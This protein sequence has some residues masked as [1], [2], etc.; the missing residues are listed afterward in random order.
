MAREPGW[1]NDGHQFT[2]GGL[3]AQTFKPV[4][5]AFD[6]P[7]LCVQAFE[8]TAVDQG[9]QMVTVV[10][11]LTAKFPA[12]AKFT[13]SGSTGNDGAYTV[14][15]VSFVAGYTNIVTVEALPDATADGAANNWGTA[16]LVIP[17]SFYLWDQIQTPTPWDD[18]SDTLFV[19]ERDITNPPSYDNY[20]SYYDPPN[21]VSGW[22]ANDS[23]YPANA[24]PATELVIQ[25]N[26]EVGGVYVA[27]L[28]TQ[29]EGTLLLVANP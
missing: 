5:I 11:D 28:S 27:P 23:M 20:I 19:A 14:A 18:S 8:I 1:D 21:Q 16:G 26:G 25:V 12:T 2:P 3:L 4:A 13:I 15:S 24:Q 10:G 9:E 22:Y 17:A 29:G 7:E 6:D